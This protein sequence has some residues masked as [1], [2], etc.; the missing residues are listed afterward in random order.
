MG[1]FENHPSSIGD[2]FVVY[3]D[4]IE[5]AT[6]IVGYRNGDNWYNEQGVQISDPTLLQKLFSKEKFL[7]YLTKIH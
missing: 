1:R 7:H 2:D 4:N 6:R 3:V 5:D